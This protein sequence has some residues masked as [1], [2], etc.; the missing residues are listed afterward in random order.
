MRMYPWAQWR[1]WTLYVEGC[2]CDAWHTCAALSLPLQHVT[3][4]AHMISPLDRLL[5]GAA[6]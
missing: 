6:F 2:P 4:F 3:E 5:V 1:S